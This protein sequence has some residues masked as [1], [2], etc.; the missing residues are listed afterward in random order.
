MTCDP[1]IDNSIR[2]YYLPVALDGTALGD[3]VYNKV[4]ITYTYVSP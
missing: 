4:I 1:V 3:L 2:A